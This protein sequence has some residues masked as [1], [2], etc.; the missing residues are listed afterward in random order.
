MALHRRRPLLILLATAL[1]AVLAAA[2]CSGVRL[3]YNTAD[4]FIQDYADDYLGLHDAQKARWTP[5]LDAALEQHRAEELPHLAA[6]F[7][8]ALDDVRSGFT[9][10]NLDCLLDQF[11]ALYQSH[12]RLAVQAAAPLLAELDRQQIDA[13][14][15]TFREEAREDAA[16]TG[17]KPAE[18]RARKRARRYED[19]MDWWIGELSSR[20]RGIVRDV[21]RRLPDTAPAWYEY[22]DRKRRELIALLR[23]GASEQRIERFMT[24][25]IVEFQ[26][27]PASLREARG[28][29]RQGWTDLILRLQPTFS[30]DQRSRLEQRLS[31]LRN[32]FMALQHQPRMAPTGC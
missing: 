13:L 9:R 32:D 31:R 24:N 12:F 28:A 22:R 3:A 8:T 26:D 11:E 6:F 7:D 2:G 14:E 18:R 23:A 17:A 27:M 19:N 5:I 29:L 1:A 10:D 20:Q 15:R 16:E 4:F 21:T 25:W 30:P